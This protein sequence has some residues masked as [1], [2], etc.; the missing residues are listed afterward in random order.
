MSATTPFRHPRPFPFSASAAV[1]PEDLTGQEPWSYVNLTEVSGDRGL[2][3]AQKF[4]WNLESIEFQLS[5]AYDNMSEVSSFSRV[6]EFPNPD[7]S[8]TL[9]FNETVG[10]SAFVN[11]V[12]PE[13]SYVRDPRLRIPIVTP[14][15]GSVSL[16]W[17][18]DLDPPDPDSYKYQSGVAEFR[19]AYDPGSS[20]W[21][22][23]YR[24]NFT[25]GVNFAAW[26][27]TIRNTEPT[28]D[29]GE[30]TFWDLDSGIVDLAGYT[31]PWQSFV[32]ADS[33]EFPEG[34]YSG[35][36]VSASVGFF[37]YP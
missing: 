2:G 16:S 5:G 14:A 29:P 1:P 19:I 30:F 17:T 3:E 34:D 10:G 4:W 6:F 11:A 21:R 12:P 20:R 15:V 25:V 28:W 32:Y 7:T 8:G 33:P 22:L 23:Y 37:S 18:F 31:L 13:G 9:S 36:I 27:V 26:S 35:S 24:F